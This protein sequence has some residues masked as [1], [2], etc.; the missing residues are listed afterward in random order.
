MAFD[1]RKKEFISISLFFRK[2]IFL[3]KYLSIQEIAGRSENF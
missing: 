3:I 1:T 2:Y